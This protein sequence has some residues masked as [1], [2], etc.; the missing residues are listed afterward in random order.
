MAL[1]IADFVFPRCSSGLAGC[2]P[3]WNPNIFGLRTQ[4]RPL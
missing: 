4:V 2:K 1:L 3:A